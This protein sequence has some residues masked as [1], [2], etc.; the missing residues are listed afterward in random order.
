MHLNHKCLV[1]VCMLP[2]TCSVP[3][4]IIK[5]CIPIARARFPNKG[6]NS[7]KILQAKLYKMDNNMLNKT[8]CKLN[9]LQSDTKKRLIR[10]I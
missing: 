10:K 9:P 2:L 4:K 6:N 8:C 1:S 5:E 7:Q 3:A